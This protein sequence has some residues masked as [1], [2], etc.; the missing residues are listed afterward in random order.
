MVTV[1]LALGAAVAY[2]LS[3]FIGGVVSRRTSVWPVALTACLGAAIGTLVLALVLPG[4]PTAADYRLGTAG[5]RGQ[6]NRHRRS[7]TGASPR[8]GWA[9]WRPSPPWARRCCPP[10]SGWSTGE[11]P[12]PPRLDGDASWPCR[13]SG[14]SPAKPSDG[15]AGIRARRRAG[16]R[17]ARRSGLRS[18]LR[19]AGSGSGRGRLLA[20]GRH[21]GGLDGR[22]RRRCPAARR[23]TRSPTGP[24]SGGAWWRGCWPPRRRRVPARPPAGP[25]QRRGGAHLALPRVHRAAGH[26][27]A[28][29]R[30]HRG[31][32]VG[33]ALCTVTV[34]CVALG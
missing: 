25:A 9:W 5:R 18:P 30:L 32:S 7:S 1:L 19:R 16:R 29:E 28:H 12:S 21:P 17:R 33:L 8:A 34:V 14:W 24:S 13:A 15:R 27:R 3:D 11:R 20:R 2:G 31:Q 23:A 22:R 10:R 26:A 6:R 4:D